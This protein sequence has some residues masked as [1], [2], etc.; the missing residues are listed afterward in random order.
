[1]AITHNELVDMIKVA[2]PL[3]DDDFALRTI[4]MFPNWE[5]NIG[6]TLTNEDLA[7]GYDRY[8]HNGKLYKVVQAT[9]FQTQYEPGA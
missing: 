6:L 4:D 7:K 9:T 2:R 5:S 1:M 3:M 8:Q